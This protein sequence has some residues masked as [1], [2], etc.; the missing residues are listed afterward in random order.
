[1]KRWDGEGLKTLHYG[2]KLEGEAK[3][4]NNRRKRYATPR[5]DVVT[6][7]FWGCRRATRHQQ[8]ADDD[9][10]STNNQQ[11]IVAHR[12]SHTLVVRALNSIESGNDALPP[13]FHILYL[14]LCGKFSVLLLLRHSPANS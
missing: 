1:M 13:F 5:E 7:L 3:D 4:H 2:I 8:E 14:F 10:H 6:E 9:N 11:H 12:Q